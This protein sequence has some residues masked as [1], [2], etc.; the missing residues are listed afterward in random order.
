MT[1]R[2]IVGATL[3]VEVE[4]SIEAKSASEARSLFRD[5]LMV[6]TELATDEVDFDVIKDNIEAIQGL[7]IQ[8]E[9]DAPQA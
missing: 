7:T 3:Q 9:A 8:E 5:N 6:L 1:M 4:M 2:Y